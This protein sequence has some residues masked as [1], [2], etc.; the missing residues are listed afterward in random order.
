MTI[1][2]PEPL[3]AHHDIDGFSC[4]VVSLDD[5]LRRRARGNQASGASR[6]FVVCEGK[7]VIAYYAL[8]SSSVAAVAVTTRF[9]RNM[10]DPVPVVVLARLAIDQEY[11]G[12]G[13]GRALVKDASLRV[14]GASEL[15]GIRG[16]IVHAI[17]EDA[18]AFY[19]SLGFSESPTNPMTLMVSLDD[20][21][22]NL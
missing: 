1:S 7:R 3:A 10:P 21:K 15:M 9:R 2:A 11:H 4:G 22:A 17:S 5:W 16:L 18:K 13:M 14:I 8:A 20:L 12:K 6:T 19:A